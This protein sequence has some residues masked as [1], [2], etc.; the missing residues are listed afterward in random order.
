MPRYCFIEECRESSYK[1][2]SRK[3]VRFPKNTKTFLCDQHFPKKF[4]GKKK[5]KE[6]SYEKIKSILEEK[7][8]S[9]PMEPLPEKTMKNK[10]TFSRMCVVKHCQMTDRSTKPSLRF[11]IFPKT[12]TE[13]YDVWMEKCNL[14]KA[15]RTKAYK[16][17]CEKHFLDKMDPVPNCNLTSPANLKQTYQF[18]K[19]I[20]D[21]IVT[22]A[23]QVDG[24]LGNLEV[25]ALKFF[26]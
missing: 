14:S 11:V 22:T 15:D 5:L 12:D 16:Y 1:N 4:F 13:L 24:C 8:I 3:L 6:T 2:P 18:S 17:V 19:F 23:K 20:E 10:R 25:G 7:G 26:L 21:E 9:V